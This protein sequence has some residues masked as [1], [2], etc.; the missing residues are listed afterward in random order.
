MGAKRHTHKTQK[1]TQALTYRIA[2][3]TDIDVR[4]KSMTIKGKQRWPLASK[5]IAEAMWVILAHK[6]TQMWGY[7]HRQQEDTHQGHLNHFPTNFPTQIKAGQHL[8]VS[9]YYIVLLFALTSSTII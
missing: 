5:S 1:L 4:A 2:V 8:F 6:Y 9:F 7:T 3:K